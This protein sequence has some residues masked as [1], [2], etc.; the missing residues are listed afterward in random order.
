M[1]TTR[2]PRIKK[3]NDAYHETILKRN[4]EDLGQEVHSVGTWPPTIGKLLL[5]LAPNKEETIY[6]KV[7]EESRSGNRSLLE[8]YI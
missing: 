4:Q 1:N 7:R 5:F 3:E 2:M 8:L 6:P